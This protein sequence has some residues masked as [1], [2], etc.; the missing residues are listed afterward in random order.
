VIV[1]ARHLVGALKGVTT[2]DKVRVIPCGIDLERFKPLDPL[3]CK[4]RLGWSAGSFHVLFASSNGDPVKRPWL[5]RAAVAQMSNSNRPS[6]LHCMTGIPN[7]EVPLWLNA[8]DVLLLTSMHEG[9]PTVVKEALACGLPVISVDVGDVAER[10]EGIEG[11]HVAGPQP[12][13]LAAMLCLV[14]RD[15]KR[16]D[17][18]TRLKELSIVSVAQQLKRCYEDI[19]CESRATRVLASPNRLSIPCV[20]PVNQSEVLTRR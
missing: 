5:A 12:S 8:S 7:A 19:T 17:C 13:D 6:E 3:I 2:G 10:I 18:G 14:Q 4:Q 9:S 11:C 16:L 1:V 15:G 20:S